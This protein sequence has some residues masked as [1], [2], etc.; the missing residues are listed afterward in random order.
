MSHLWDVLNELKPKAMLIQNSFGTKAVGHFDHY[1]LGTQT[2]TGRNMSIAFNKGLRQA[3][4]KAIKT[5]WWNERP[6]LWI[7]VR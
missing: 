7:K 3:G 5:G 6:K 4:W 2:L 1:K